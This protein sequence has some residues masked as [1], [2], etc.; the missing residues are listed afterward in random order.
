MAWC[1][2]KFGCKAVVFMPKGTSEF[3]LR[4]IQQH[5]AHVEITDVNY[6]DTVKYAESESKKNQWILLQDSSWPGY[7]NVAKHIMSGYTTM[8]HEFIEQ[9]SEW[10]THVIA[11]AGVGSFAASIFSCFLN[12]NIKQPKL[13]LLE[14]SGAACFYNSLN[15]GDGNPHLT[16][17]LDT[18]MAGLSCGMP[19]LL[20]W[21]I[22]C[23]SADFFT[24]CNDSIA[25]KGMQILAKPYYNDMPIVSGESGAVP[26]GLLNEICTNQD[27]INLREE[28]CLDSDSTV[29][30]FSTEGDT[31]PDLYQRVVS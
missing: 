21:N 14:P 26:L 18:I 10:P 28:L 15:V 19:S 3:R 2:E 11:Q 9:T 1:A 29:L 20:A 24:I 6:D 25:I 13:I 30:F 31:D 23:S 16:K 27:Y 12:N 5:H 17:H 7:E 8:V 22:I 4:A